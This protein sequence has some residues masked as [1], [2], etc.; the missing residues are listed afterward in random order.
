MRI[1]LL[2]ALCTLG[3]AQNSAEQR[4]QWNQP[5]KPFRILGN[6]YY[7]GAANV[8]SFFIQTP[9]GAILLDGGLPETAPVIEKNIADLGF[10]IKD[11][12]ILLNSHAHFDHCG[13][14]AE[15]K[16]RS[17]AQMIASE[18]DRPVLDTSQGGFGAFPAVKVDHV[19]GDRQTVQLGGVTLTA[20]LTPGHTKGCTTWSMPVSSGKTYQVVFYC[21]TTVVDKLVNNSN[22]PG[23][24]SDYMRSFAELRRIPCDVF[25]APHA[26][27]FKLD[28]KR[29]QLDEGK[30]D[31]FVDPTEM[32]KFV[33]E[34]EQAFRRELD[35]QIHQ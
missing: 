6:I 17:G 8:S 21:S 31:A 35:E 24:V 23:I 22:Y 18:R 12:K 15:L 2:F 27:F 29:K 3:C 16:K 28:E 11:V 4:A 19:I 34:S 20:H 30:L 33:N 7:V 13:G 26:G 25:L 5:V 32:Q 14:L 9:E 1:F 10:S